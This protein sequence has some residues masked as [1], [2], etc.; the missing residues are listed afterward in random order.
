[1]ARV[2]SVT[3]A[4]TADVYNMQVDKVNNFAVN[5]GLIVHNCDALRYFAIGW[6][7]KANPRAVEENNPL[8]GFNVK[9]E[10][11]SGGYMQW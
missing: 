4:G 6:T 2:I 10:R 11:R 9:R 1:M 3:E 7:Y 8:E 5:G